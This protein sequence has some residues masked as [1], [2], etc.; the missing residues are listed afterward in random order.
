MREKC[1]T[2]CLYF[3]QLMYTYQVVF[4]NMMEIR[5]LIVSTFIEICMQIR[6]TIIYE[7]LIEDC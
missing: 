2:N 1:I 3:K 7:K 5:Y 4:Y 6:E